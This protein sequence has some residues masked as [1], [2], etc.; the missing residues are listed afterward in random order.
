[1]RLRDDVD[2]LL[3][4]AEELHKLADI[5]GFPVPGAPAT[6]RDCPSMIAD[7]ASASLSSR[8]SATG[9]G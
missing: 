1:M 7:R 9:V 4:L 6:S 2:P 5:K 8:Q 3:L